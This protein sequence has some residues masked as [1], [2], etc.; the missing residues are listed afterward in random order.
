MSDF[1]TIAIT[2]RWKIVHPEILEKVIAFLQKKRKTIL[3]SERVQKSLKGDFLKFETLNYAKKFD[4]LITFG[5]DGTILRAAR[6]LQHLNTAVLGIN[7]GHLGFLT[8]FGINEI[9]TGLENIFSGNYRL[10]KKFLFKVQQKREGKV[11]LEDKIL[12]DVVISY[13]NVARIINIDV[14]VGNRELNEYSADGLIISTPTGSTA[15][16]LAAGGPIM[17]PGVKALIVTPICS[18]SFTQKPIVLPADKKIT[19]TFK[20]NNDPTTL[21]L[22]GQKSAELQANDEVVIELMEESL[23]LIRKKDDFY[24]KILKEKLDW[25]K[26]VKKLPEL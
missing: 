22:D 13:R 23:S 11:I 3:V 16:N 17:Y 19:L 20:N 25:G 21:T 24:F 6:D 2:T 1:N 5:G 9:K 4:L 18:H 12:N 7:A 8:T 14:Q 26:G 15:Y 10:V